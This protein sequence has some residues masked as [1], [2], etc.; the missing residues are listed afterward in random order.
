MMDHFSLARSLLLLMQSYDAASAGIKHIIKGLSH[1]D[2]NIVLAQK[3]LE[4]AT[5]TN[6]TLLRFAPAS[7]TTTPAF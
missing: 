4:G 2:V 6:T 7:P 1:F 5:A 3:R